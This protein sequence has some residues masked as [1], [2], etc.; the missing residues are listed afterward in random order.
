[1]LA[2]AL[3]SN[4]QLIR[5][6]FSTKFFFATGYS[7]LLGPKRCMFSVDGSDRCWFVYTPEK[8]RISVWKQ[9]ETTSKSGSWSYC[10]V[11]IRVRLSIFIP[12]KKVQTKLG[13]DLWSV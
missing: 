2:A 6:E 9:T 10:L 11:R 3:L 12:S 8:K 5:Y 4:I 13:N 7:G 1:M